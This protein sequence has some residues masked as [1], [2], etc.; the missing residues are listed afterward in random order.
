[1]SDGTLRTMQW[2]VAAV[3][4]LLLSAEAEARRGHGG[5]RNRGRHHGGHKRPGG[6]HRHDS[7]ESDESDESDDG[8]TIHRASKNNTVW[9]R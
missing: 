2:A 7:D 3:I 5:D 9:Y 8:L 6:H 1:M 4:I